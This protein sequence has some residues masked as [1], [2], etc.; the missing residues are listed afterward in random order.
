MKETFNVAIIYGSAR[1]GRFCDT[2]TSWVVET[3]KTDRDISLDTIDPA[4]LNL[5][6]YNVGAE[7]PGVKELHTALSDADAFIVVTPEYN[8]SFTGELKL[9]IDAAK[10][11]W[12]RKPVAFV[13][14]GGM[15]GGLRAVEQ[16]RLVFAEL[17]AVSMRDVVSFANAWDRFD[18]TGKP[19]D[20]EG[21]NG[22]LHRMT[23]DLKWWASA[24]REA[25]YPQSKH[26]LLEA[27][28]S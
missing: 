12:R 23:A 22:A 3:L 21:T 13:S 4:A 26:Q 5:P 1:Q 2:V 20:L 19:V 16:L 9:L 11:Q 17:Q 15:S 8:H 6:A 25:R 18:D 27:I 7:H 28:A 24:L 14:Y 10:Q